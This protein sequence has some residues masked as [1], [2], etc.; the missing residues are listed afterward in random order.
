MSVEV[1]YMVIQKKRRREEVKAGVNGRRQTERRH[2]SVAKR[3]AFHPVILA[4]IFRATPH[5]STFLGPHKP[6]TVLQFDERIEPFM[7]PC[8]RDVRSRAW[9]SKSAPPLPA[10][11]LQPKPQNI[12]ANANLS[13]QSAFVCPD[14][15]GARE[16]LKWTMMEAEGMLQPF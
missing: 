1:A 8:A 5:W 12:S 16:E 14:D 7:L 4:M 9:R 11:P 15:D 10:L 3:N 13:S 6:V 2:R